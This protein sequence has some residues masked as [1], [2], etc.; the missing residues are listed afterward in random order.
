VFIL[1]AVQPDIT[2]TVRTVNFHVNCWLSSHNSIAI[3]FLTVFRKVF[4]QKYIL[5]FTKFV[6]L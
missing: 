2:K 4:M 5:Q 1:I 3:E 6:L